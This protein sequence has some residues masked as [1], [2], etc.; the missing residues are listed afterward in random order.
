MCFLV[1]LGR[2]VVAVGI[3]TLPVLQFFR[4]N[5]VVLG[6]LSLQ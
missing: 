3:D 1:V 6:F 4:C 5:V 2:G